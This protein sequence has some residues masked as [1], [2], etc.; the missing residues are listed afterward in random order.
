MSS[1]MRSRAVVPAFNGGRA[2]LCACCALLYD[3]GVGVLDATYETKGIKLYAQY[4]PLMTSTNSYPYSHPVSPHPSP[5]SQ[6]PKLPNDQNQ[7]TLP[8]LP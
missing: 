6:T 1:H 2:M 8:P 3:V 7:H 5:N 4:I